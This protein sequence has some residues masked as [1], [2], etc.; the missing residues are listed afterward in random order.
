MGPSATIRV[1]HSHLQFNN[2]SKTKSEY[3]WNRKSHLSYLGL[4]DNL[5]DME[6]KFE[7]HFIEI[8]IEPLY[9]LLASFSSVDFNSLVKRL[10]LIRIMSLA[11]KESNGI[12]IQSEIVIYM[13]LHIYNMYY[14]CIELWIFGRF[15]W[16]KKRMNYFAWEERR[17]A[18]LQS[19]NH[20]YLPNYSTNKS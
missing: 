16:L 14:T 6:W 10:Y 1:L 20:Q 13:L 17:F 7:R 18:F 19:L 11:N 5:R 8:L 2:I 12:G 4:Q 15:F 9:A 3:L